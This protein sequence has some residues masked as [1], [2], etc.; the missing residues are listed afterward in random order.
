MRRKISV[1][2][3]EQLAERL[4]AA[5]TLLGARKSSIVETAVDRFLDPQ[6]DATGSA[7]SCRFD[8]ISRGLDGLEHDLKI[9]G[10]MVAL[11]ARYHLTVTPALPVADQS[12]ACAIGRERFEEFAAQVARRVYLNLPLMRETMDRMVATRPGLFAH[13]R[14]HDVQPLA[15]ESA[16]SNGFGGSAGERHEAEL[17]T[18]S[19]D[20]Q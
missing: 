1:R 19:E 11:H 7:M 15:A 8:R 14:Q 2:I 6:G 16:D 10:E 3:S 4:E 18:A 12:G 13:E 20:E 9:V 17:A 5:A